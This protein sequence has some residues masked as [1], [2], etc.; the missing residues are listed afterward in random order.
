[1]THFP[2][3]RARV[4]PCCTSAAVRRSRRQ[5]V[6]EI[7]LLRLLLLRPY[8]CLSCSRRFYGFLFSRKGSG[9]PE[10]RSASRT[11]LCLPVRLK[12]VGG[13][14]Q[15]SVETLLT[16]DIGEGGVC[17]I[18]E[19]RIEPGTPVDLEIEIESLPQ[20]PRNIWQVSARIVRAEAHNGT[21]AYRLAAAFDRVTRG[22]TSPAQ[23]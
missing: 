8:R 23:P 20:A 2:W 17:F 19:R 22:E 4:C 9:A 7:L 5:G 3:R 21:G 13:Q 15:A 11:A 14:P 10:R 6:F 16:R 18:A 1:M 12:G